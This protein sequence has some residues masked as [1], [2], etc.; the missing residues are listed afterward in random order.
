MTQNSDP[1]WFITGC[2]TGFGLELAR[3]II[4]RGWRAV[5]T[6]RDRAKVDDLARGAEDRVLALSLDV[7]EAGQIRES[8]RAATDT[9]GRID[10][11]VNNA[12]YGYQSSI[13]EGE[14]DKVRAQFDANVFGLF[15]LTRAVLPVMRSQRSGHI[16]NITSVA[17]FVG[18]PAS[19]YYAATKHAVEGFSD[20][21][22]AEAGPL[23]IR[24]ICIEPGPFRT[25]W[26]GRSLVQ[27]PNAIPDY[28]ETAG[29]RL[30]ATSEKSGTQAGDPVRAGEAMIRV[31]EMEN[32][33]RHLVLGAWGYDAVT[34]RLKQRLA[35]IEA[36]RETSL[37]ADYPQP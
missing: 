17:G 33:P 35:E 26:A 30:K 11:L 18:F 19:G 37:G 2:S 14:E 8:V 32:P 4:G 12:G 21:L 10:V 9:F 36:W 29:A 28:A 22:A 24:V 15:A 27:T 7:T 31:T 16:L 34:S 1:V 6:A 13:E 20:S 25:D 5:V 3:L 23:G